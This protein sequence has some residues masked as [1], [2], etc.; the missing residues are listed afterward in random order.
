[1]AKNAKVIFHDL[2]SI[3]LSIFEKTGVNFKNQVS[4]TATYLSGGLDLNIR[5]A[6]LAKIGGIKGALLQ[7]MDIDQVVFYAEI[8]F[9]AL[10]SQINRKLVVE[11]LSKYPEVRRDLSIV[12]DENVSFEE[13]K[14]ITYT[15]D[16]KLIKSIN[17][18]DI[19]S[20]ENLEK[21]KKSYSVNYILS[22]TESTLKDTV[23]DNLMNRLIDAYEAQL[24]AVIRR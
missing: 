2:S 18:F 1:M 12:L 7:K 22:D 6:T 20:G 21:G 3:V 5:K 13:V 14:K 16:N 11:E 23:I 15:I 19:Y 17:V 24:K 9:D 4:T 8:D 10:M